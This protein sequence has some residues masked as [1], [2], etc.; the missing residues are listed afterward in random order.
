MPSSSD[1][2]EGITQLPLVVV[3]GTQ[4]RYHMYHVQPSKFSYME[5]HTCQ[6]SYCLQLIWFIVRLPQSL[7]LSDATI[8]IRLIILS[9]TDTYGSYIEYLPLPQVVKF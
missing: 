7:V 9:C 3:G 8:T 2:P 5:E 6:S 1:T 4:C